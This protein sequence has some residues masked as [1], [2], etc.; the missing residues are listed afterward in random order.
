MGRQNAL[1]AAGKDERDAPTQIFGRLAGRGGDQERQRLG[2]IPPGIIVDEPVAVGLA[3]DANDLPRIDRTRR[4]G[5]AQSVDI[6]GIRE[7]KPMDIRLH[8]SSPRGRGTAG[9]FDFDQLTTWLQ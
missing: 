1:D 4:D 3:D 9:G 2:Q 5:L 7:R 6:A 8:N